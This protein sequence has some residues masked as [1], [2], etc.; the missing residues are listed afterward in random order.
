M[1][2]AVVVAVVDA[3]DVADVVALDEVVGVLLPV[4]LGDDVGVDVPVVVGVVVVVVVGV[5]LVVDV[6]VEVGVVTSQ[7]ENPPSE[8]ASIIVFMIWTVALQALSKSL[9]KKQLTAGAGSRVAPGPLNSL[10]ARLIRCAV[11]SHRAKSATTSRSPL[12]PTSPM[13]AAPASWA[14]HEPSSVF[15]RLTCVPQWPLVACRARR[16][17]EVQL[18]GSV[19]PCP[20]GCC[21]RRQ[22]RACGAGRRC[23]GG[24]RAG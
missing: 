24:R 12:Q 6:G 19:E 22:R 14:A 3:V 23:C 10:A 9:P 13:C 21:R 15:K 7:P 4:V 11:A 18:R 20:R 5:V 16:L 1:D 17:S 2:V 8:Y